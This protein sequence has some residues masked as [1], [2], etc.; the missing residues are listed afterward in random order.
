M[1][2]I[3][4]AHFAGLRCINKVKLDRS[5]AKTLVRSCKHCIASQLMMKGSG[6]STGH[7]GEEVGQ[8]PVS[9]WQ[10][11]TIILTTL[12]CCRMC[13]QEVRGNQKVTSQN[14]EGTQEALSKY[15][16]DL[17]A[18]A[19]EGKLDPVSSPPCDMPSD[20]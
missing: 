1:K 12:T 4:D 9:A 8:L 3:D 2:H 17:T 20:H 13:Q 6:Q 18:A 11:G 7:D 19:A 10:H 5:S 15:A 14:P 16:R